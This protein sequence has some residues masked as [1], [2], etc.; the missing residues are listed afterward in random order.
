MMGPSLLAMISGRRFLC[1]LGPALLCL[2]ALVAAAAAPP[3]VL[4]QSVDYPGSEGDMPAHLYMP[5]GAGRF[6][7]ILLLHTLAGPGPNLEAFARR[8]AGEGFV[9]MTPDFFM[10]HD[11]GPE[12][13]IDH[14]LVLKDLDGAL[15]HLRS[16]PKVDSTRLAVVGFSFGGRLGVIAAARYPDLKAAVIYYAIASFQELSK[17]RPVDPRALRTRPVTELVGSI[18][19]TVQIH[20][21]EADRTV[22]ARQA[23]LLQDALRGAGKSSTLNLY[24]GADHLFN[25]SIPVEGV[26]PDPEAGRLSWQ[27]TVEFLK[28]HLS[29]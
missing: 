1:A 16:H 12:T 21:G 25:F 6:P 5:E 3:R 27:R 4:E 19:A 13:R 28:R 26:T 29:N 9:T 10:L 7:G 2:A 18:R 14:P 20:H 24:P 17:D 22:P 8:L 15:A 11:F 23:R